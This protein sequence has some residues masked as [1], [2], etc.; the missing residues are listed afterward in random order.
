MRK[1]A[2][3]VGDDLGGADEDL[4]VEGGSA[5][6]DLHVLGLAGHGTRPGDAAELGLGVDAY[7]RAA[8]Q[9]HVRG[10]GLDPDPGPALGDLG[11]QVGR[12]RLDQQVDRT[13]DVGDLRRTGGD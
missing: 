1:G 6:A 8:A 13:A 7:V 5:A 12:T 3:S 11:V 9:V 10:T 4:D 2:G